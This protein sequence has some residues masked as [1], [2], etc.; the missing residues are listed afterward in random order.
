MNDMTAKQ[1]VNAFLTLGVLTVSVG[2]SLGI[3][4]AITYRLFRLLT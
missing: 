1:I 4:A 2:A 3:A